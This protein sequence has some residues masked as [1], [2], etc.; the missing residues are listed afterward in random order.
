MRIETVEVLLSLLSVVWNIYAGI[1]VDRIH[2]GTKGLT[3]DEQ[4]GFRSGRGCVCQ[5]FTLRQI[6][7]KPREKK[8]KIYIGFM[9]LK[10][11]YDKG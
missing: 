9:N 6:G 8:Q 3:D 11:T 7:E 4:G 10:K 1:L 5:S 2:R